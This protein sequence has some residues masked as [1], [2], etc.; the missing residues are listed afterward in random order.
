MGWMKLPSEVEAERKR[1]EEEEKKGPKFYDLWGND[2]STKLSKRHHAHIA[3]P[4][5]KLPGHDESYNPLPEYL[6][7]EEEV[8]WLQVLIEIQV[9]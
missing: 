6:P 3:A 4:K 5:L 1:K 8:S 9:S 2:E 7:T